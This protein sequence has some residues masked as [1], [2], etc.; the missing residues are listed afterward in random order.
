MVSNSTW[1]RLCRD[2]AAVAVWEQG[3]FCRATWTESESKLSI[4]PF[5]ILL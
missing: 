2:E 3:P 5:F 4:K 1:G